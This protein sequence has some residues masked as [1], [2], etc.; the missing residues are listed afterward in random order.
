M[1]SSSAATS[2]SRRP[3]VALIVET[4]LASGRDI[5][6]GIARYVHE[7]GPWSI[8]HE[9]RS[10]EETVP[11]W[12]KNWNGNGIIARIQNEEIARAVAEIKLPTVDVLGVVPG[13]GFPLV[14]VDD[15]AIG[16]AGA[17]HLLE[18]G[19]RHFGFV[20]IGGENW[21]QARG[22]AF[23]QRIAAA[24][25]AC[26]TLEIARRSAHSGSWERYE[27]DLA[28]W[29][30]QLPKPAGVMIASDQL[31]TALLEACRR[32]GV[33]VPDDVAVIGVDND[34]PLCL[35][36]DPP[37]TSI[38]PNHAQVGYEAARLLDQLM[39]GQPPPTAPIY[40][41]PGDI[42]S[43]LSTSTLAVEDRMVASAARYIREHACSGINVADVVRQTDVC[44]SVLQRRF[45]DAFQRTIHDE[46]VHTRLTRAKELLRDTELPLA[47][48][49]VKAGFQHQ[50][51]L[52]A[53]FKQRLHTTPAKYRI[54]SRQE[55]R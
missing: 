53:V 52:G 50:E 40:L 30:A 4:S 12:L 43:R 38:W 10:L 44:R 51:Y 45:K 7:H 39:Q 25:H 9:P 20:S 15:A 29:L 24:G 21:S 1:A 28:R 11:R 49:A 6:Q 46:I 3:R 22:Q 42:V 14:H 27:A 16:R 31:G 5:L 47:T 13:S 36:S 37:L 2:V 23:D 34:E 54:D 33:N 18:R 41:S 32:A 35:V 8:Y 55:N 17:E 19:F 48:I 26:D